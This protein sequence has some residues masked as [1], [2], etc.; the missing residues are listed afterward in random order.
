MSQQQ[1]SYERQQER[2]AHLQKFIDRFKAKATKARQA[3]SRV[4]AL[5]RMEKLAPVLTAA[6]FSFEFRE[7]LSLP[8]PMLVMQGR[9]SAVRARPTVIVRGVNRSVLAG[10]RIGILGA[11]GQGKSTLV[12]TIARE[13]PGLGGTITEGKGL[14]IGY[15]AQQEMD[16]LQARRRAARAHDPASPRP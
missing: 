4:K 3:Q 8:N 2:I 13:L 6:D 16:V 11:N 10:Q 12:K 14:A 9:R 15:F 7:P 5:A 1:A